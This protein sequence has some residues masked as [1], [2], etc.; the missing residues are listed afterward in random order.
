MTSNKERVEKAETYH[1]FVATRRKKDNDAK[2]IC[3]RQII[4]DERLDLE[5]LKGRIKN[6]SG[7]WRIYKTVNAR[8]VRPAMKMLMKKLIDHPE[9]Y[10]FKI[11]VL[12]RSCLLQ[13]ECNEDGKFM[14]DVDEKEIPDKLNILHKNNK[15]TFQEMIK[16]PNGWHLIC[17]KLDTRILEGIPNVS[18]KRDGIKFVELIKND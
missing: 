13:S 4:R 18:V 16:T 8:K 7:I 11:D 15:F 9:E 2:E 5:S 12:W 6:I 1:M 14:I 17:D 3:F 10:E